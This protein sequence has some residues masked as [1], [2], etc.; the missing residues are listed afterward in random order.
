[1]NILTTEKLGMPKTVGMYRKA[2][3]DSTSYVLNFT[4]YFKLYLSYELL[5]LFTLLLSSSSGNERK[6]KCLN[7][8]AVTGLRP[9]PGGPIAPTKITSIIVRNSPIDLRSY[10]PE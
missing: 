3:Y 10:H 5:Y 1:M 7:K 8:R 9:P 6:W 2:F 4:I